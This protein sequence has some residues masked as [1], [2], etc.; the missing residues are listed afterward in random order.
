M[1][2]LRVIRGL[3]SVIVALFVV[4]FAIKQANSE[5]VAKELK[6]LPQSILNK[7]AKENILVNAPIYMRAFKEEGIVEV[8]LQAQN[9][10]FK[11]IKSYP[12]CQWSGKLGPKY[13][14]GD[15][16]TPE[17]FYTITPGQM[18]PKSNYHLAFNLGFPNEFDK[19][20]GRKGSFLMVHGFCKSV[21]CYAMTNDGIE[22]IFGF[23]RDAF[24]GGQQ[25][26]S[27]DAYPFKMTAKN[28]SRYAMDENIAFWTELKKGYDVFQ[29]THRP[30]R[31]ETCQKKY[32]VTTAQDQRTKTQICQSGDKGLI[33]KLDA[34]YQRRYMVDYIAASSKAGKDGTS[35]TMQAPKR[36]NKD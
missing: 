36:Q 11:L 31:V 12:I 14:E 35:P 26:F 30:A 7:I 17:G 27:F 29:I 10:Q 1:S 4:F 15:H 18:H 21:G 9:G 28:M 6:A 19:A 25:S 22:E 16:Q 8:W 24:Q 32:V 13:Q 33:E 5:P 34:K 2:M 20:N 23:A 3:I